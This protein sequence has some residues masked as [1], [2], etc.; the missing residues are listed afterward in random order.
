MRLHSFR[1]VARGVFL[2]LCGISA[3]CTAQ[4]PAI[5]LEVEY[6]GCEA[7]LLPGPVCR[8]DPSRELRL[9]IGAPEARIEIQAGERR[10][11]TAGEPVGEGQRFSLTMPARVERV[12]VLV[13]TQ[14]GKASWSLSLAEPEGEESREPLVRQ[15]R[16]EMSRDL[17]RE[18]QQTAESVRDLILN[19]QLAAARRMLDDLR[20]P[21]K[22]PAELRCML[23][24]WRGMLAEKEGDHRSALA[25][26]Q[27]AVQIAKRMKEELFQ[28]QSEQ[29][30]ALFLRGV[31]R[32]RESAAV[33]ERLGRTPHAKDPCDRA[34][35]LNNQAWSMLLA[36]EGGERLG[37][38][39]PLL[40]RALETYEKCEHF[41]F[42]K[43]LNI[44]IN[45]AL[46]HL[47]ENRLAYATDLLAQAR[48]LEAHATLLQMLWWLDLE[49]RIALRQERP[50]EALRLFEGLEEL[51]VGTSSPD[52]RLRAVFGQAQSHEALGDRTAA[53][54]TLRK[55]ET[56]LDEQSLQVPVHEGRGTFMATRQAV[57]NLYVALLLEVG[58]REEALDVV[59]Q[60]RSRMLRQLERSD[61]L[62]S[63]KPEQRARWDGLLM[64]Y[65]R[66]RA[67][68]ED[69]AKGY[70]R[71]PKDQFRREQDARAAE[72]EAATR[73]LDEAFLILEG[74]GE[75]LEKVF[76]SPRPG[77]LILAYHPLPRG[78]AGFAADGKSVVVHRFDLPAE[79]LSP[80][81]MQELAR[82]LLLPFRVPIERAKKIRVLPSGPLQEVDFHALPFDGDILLASAPV[83]YGL[84]LPVSTGP[85]Q[86]PGRR[87]LL[88]ADPRDD[89]PG[90]LEEAR[91]VKDA[92][93]A[94]ITEELRSEEASEEAV[95]DRLAAVDL[96]HYA[97][98][99]TFS[100][101]GGWE[102][103][104][105]LADNTR[106]TLGDVLALHRVPAW[107]VLSGCDTGRSSTETP[108]EGLGLAHAF[109]L[110]G[111]QAV[112]GS[113]RK[114]DDREVPRFFS[115]L[116]Q[117]WSGEPDL[118]VALQ[119]AQLSW[120]KR[121]PGADW[122]GFRL[123]EP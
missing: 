13:E 82:R 18:G 3:V 29:M 6:A 45:L 9:W 70:W 106:L 118:A 54:Q 46:A 42:Q 119:R 83:V 41:T 33:F 28:W 90:T 1:G 107:V 15:A 75:R 116:Y 112:I 78:W 88:V 103:S 87:A 38:P 14:E 17:I 20:L 62:A 55:A 7:V 102:S 32:S 34:Q 4:V 66:K 22:A 67:A 114:A 117:E 89:L 19:R 61:R 39:A 85:V 26:M 2:F 92:L 91:R 59:R 77:E 84:D 25:E 105:R 53:L 12:G 21:P 56:L 74:P 43:K 86:V 68:L 79:N 58:R 110:V 121:N 73:I 65:Q 69:R 109:L 71:L 47:Q 94:W 37:D 93:G 10:I 113:T 23:A 50:A 11:D 64:D 100:G 96:L 120:R 52:G 104:L 97:G 40:E 122:R 8:L 108:V 76:P 51:A 81:D 27:T 101:P 63:L 49:A 115:E 48:Q 99:G 24:Y 31:G 16:Q 57:V 60:A 30:L 98:H 5:P 36:R 111:S 80:L 95:R 72:A 123:F 35:F 44:L